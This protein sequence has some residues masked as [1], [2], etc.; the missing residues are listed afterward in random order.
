MKQDLIS[1]S[2]KSYNRFKLL[3]LFILLEE[4]EDGLD[5]IHLN[6]VRARD[7]IIW[8]GTGSYGSSNEPSAFLQY[9]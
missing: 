8:Q 2:Q 6:Q 3:L 7:R 4:K 9:G 1:F 5:W